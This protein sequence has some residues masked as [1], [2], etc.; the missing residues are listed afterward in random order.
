MVGH[1]WVVESMKVASCSS[2][3][4]LTALVASFITVSYYVNPSMCNIT[5]NPLMWNKIKYSKYMDTVAL[6]S[7]IRQYNS[8]WTYN[9]PRTSKQDTI[10]VQNSEVITNTHVSSVHS[11]HWT[12]VVF[13][14]V[15]W[16]RNTYRTG[17]RAT[18][19]RRRTTSL[20]LRIIQ[21]GRHTL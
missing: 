17:A 14:F 4:Y 5:F 10:S 6:R 16:A 2:I 3:E 15:V 20:R 21:K 18:K 7:Q 1:I 13:Y 11:V 8:L 19:E 12:R 9:L